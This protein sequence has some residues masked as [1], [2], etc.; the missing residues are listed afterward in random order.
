MRQSGAC[1]HLETCGRGQCMGCEATG[2]DIACRA[3]LEQA[4]GA[5]PGPATPGSA[6]AV[7]RAPAE[8]S[9]GAG[10]AAGRSAG[11]ASTAGA[12][13]QVREQPGVANGR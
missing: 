2:P 8:S 7:G 11:P 3:V 4:L 10:S 1:L 5:D 13:A 6:S 12:S 9:H